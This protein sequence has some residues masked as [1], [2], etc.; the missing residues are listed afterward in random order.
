MV[1]AHWG[2]RRVFLY[3]WL[4]LL[5]ARRYSSASF[6]PVYVYLLW[7]PLLG[8]LFGTATPDTPH[9][10]WA[11]FAIGLAAYRLADIVNFYLGLFFD[12]QQ[13]RFAGIE[14]SLLCLMGNVVELVFVGA[15]LLEASAN[16]SPR[17]AWFQAFGLVALVNLPELDGYWT[18]L[19]EVVVMSVGFILIAGGLGMLIGLIGRRFHD[20]DH[21]G[22]ASL[23]RRSSKKRAHRMSELIQDILKGD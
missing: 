22:P 23:Q 3:E 1:Q 18:H 16:L 7:L 14:R 4:I 11:Y 9:D 8:V 19:V 17:V 12:Q 6:G 5:W 13:D 20:A 21:V 10:G 15:I 2:L